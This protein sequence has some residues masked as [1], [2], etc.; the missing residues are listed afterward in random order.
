MEHFKKQTETTKDGP[1]YEASF[2]SCFCII[3]WYI[4]CLFVVL[5]KWS[6]HCCLCELT[7]WSVLCCSAW[8]HNLFHILSFGFATRTNT[9]NVSYVLMQS[10]TAKYGTFD[11]APRENKGWTNLWSKVCVIVLLHDMVHPLRFA[12]YNASVILCVLVVLRQIFNT[13]VCNNVC[14]I[15]WCNAKQQRM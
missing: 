4:L 14:N 13:D 8:H 11:D 9:Q 12:S 5:H 15:L 6:I 2:V 1:F 3:K 7:E 10:E